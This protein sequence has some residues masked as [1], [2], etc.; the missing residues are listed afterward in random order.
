MCNAEDAE[1]GLAYIAKL[2]SL[3]FESKLFVLD[4]AGLGKNGKSHVARISNVTDDGVL[5]IITEVKLSVEKELEK[6]NNSGLK[7]PGLDN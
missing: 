7:N 3:R 2:I 6:Q 4:V 1:N 5:S